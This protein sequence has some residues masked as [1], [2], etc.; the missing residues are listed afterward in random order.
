MTQIGADFVLGG[1]TD[2]QEV[3][4]RERWCGSIATIE[5]R[6]YRRFNLSRTF[7]EFPS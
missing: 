5:E 4:Q 1:T 7:D 3:T 6:S 2:E